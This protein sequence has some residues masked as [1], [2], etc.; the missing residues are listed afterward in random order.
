MVLVVH[1]AHVG[2]GLDVYGKNGVGTVPAGLDRK[3]VII[4]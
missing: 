1:A 2:P 3:T 4:L